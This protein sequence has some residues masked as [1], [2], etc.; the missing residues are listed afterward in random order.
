LKNEFSDK[1]DSNVKQKK[2]SK[3][4]GGGRPKAPRPIGIGGGPLNPAA[5][6]D[7]FTNG[8]SAIWPTIPELSGARGFA[9]DAVRGF[10]LKSKDFFLKLYLY[11][12]GD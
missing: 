9:M 6:T 12:I 1:L 4:G 10:P 2:T 7:A 11:S 3:L 5:G 8:A